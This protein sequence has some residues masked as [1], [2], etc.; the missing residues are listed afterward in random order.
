VLMHPLTRPL[1]R[2]AA[3]SA[4]CACF[5]TATAKAVLQVYEGF[6]YTDG[7]SIVGQNGG[8]GWSN[9][10]NA[11][12]NA[13]TTEN[14]T[15]PGLTNPGLSTTLVNNKLSLAGQ[16]TTA[17]TGNNA[18]I[19]RSVASGLT[20]GAD[21]T[22]TWLSFIGQ[23]TGT[24]A[25]TQG[26]GGTPSYQRIFGISFFQ[27]GTNSATDERWSVGELTPAAAATDPDT[28]ALNI[29]PT[30]EIQPT[31]VAIDTQSFLL[32]RLN[33]GSGA[34]SDNAY[35]WV[36][37]DLSQGEPSI[38][39]AQA[40]LLNRNLEFDRL[41]V[42]AGGSSTAGAVPAASGV[43]DEIR[44]GTSFSSVIGPGLISGDVNGDLAVNDADY[45]IIRNNF[46]ITG[47]TLA[48]GDLNGDGVVNFTDFRIWKNNK[49]P[50]SGA[51]ANLLDGTVPEPAS[52]VLLVLAIAAFSGRRI[53]R[54]QR[55]HSAA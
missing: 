25:G 24:K 5:W 7:T 48:Q 10:W 41:R 47:A 8:A 39:T 18:F 2:A 43:I 23:R 30:A 29:F 38:G 27:A 14:A 17:T 49:A 53:T 19:F 34:L 16:Q 35:L 31:S 22:T 42:S 44:I 13:S 20:L 55:T 1:A 3:C 26:T 9:A 32:V 46:Q 36:N 54:S 50:G 11:T 45:Q 51:V 6:P 21:N 37:P 40:T 4:L 12:G 33:Y 15:A 28:W 52:V